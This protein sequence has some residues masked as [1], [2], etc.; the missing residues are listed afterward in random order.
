M[1]GKRELG[2]VILTK[3][4]TKKEPVV[5]KILENGNAVECN[6]T[7]YNRSFLIV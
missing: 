3:S 2:T 5:G 4:I 1:D 7:T 6:G